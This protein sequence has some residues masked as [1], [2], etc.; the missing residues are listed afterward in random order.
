MVD[1]LDVSSLAQPEN[2][3]PAPLVH[4]Y[5]RN[6]GGYRPL[7]RWCK[8]QLRL[9]SYTQ[10]LFD[11]C[12]DRRKPYFGWLVGWWSKI[13]IT[14]SLIRLHYILIYEYLIKQIHIQCRIASPDIEK[15]RCFLHHKLPRIREMI[16][17]PALL[18][19]GF[20]FLRYLRAT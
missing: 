14:Q 1:S 8:P 15:N 4:S 11:P 9:I 7:N 2:H 20:E 3:V 13:E 5:V 16:L 10:K 17:Q 12:F 18:R 19:G 6:G